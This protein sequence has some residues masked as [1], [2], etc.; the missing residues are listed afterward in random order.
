MGEDAE[1][2]RLINEYTSV[3]L[4]LTHGTNGPRLLVVS[5][6]TGDALALDATSLEAVASMDHRGLSA[7]VAALTETGTANTAVGLD[8][9]QASLAPGEAR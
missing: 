5:D 8:E 9:V 7:L 3:R 2:A 6:R 4:S 1:I